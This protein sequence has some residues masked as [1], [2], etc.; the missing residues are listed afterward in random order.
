MYFNLRKTS[1]V[2]LGVTSVVCS[3]VM[4]VFF[5]DPE[6][7]NLLVVMVVALVLYILSLIAYSPR[8]SMRNIFQHD[9]VSSIVNLK[10]LS[11][12]IFVQ[13]IAAFIFLLIF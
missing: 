13:I 1:L 12:A 2:I 6:G 8:I 3:R 5:D 10:R 9:S 11:I 4:F 7:P